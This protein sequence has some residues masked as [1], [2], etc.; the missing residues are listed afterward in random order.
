MARK[1]P[2]KSTFGQASLMNKGASKTHKLSPYVQVSS[3]A[4][5]LTESRSQR[6][7]LRKQERN[8]RQSPEP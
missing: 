4:N 2:S 5:D 3:L 6:Q 1:Q 7:Q 8:T